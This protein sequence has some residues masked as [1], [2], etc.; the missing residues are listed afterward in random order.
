MAA[1]SRADYTRAETSDTTT[2]VPLLSEDAME[3]DTH[4][5]SNTDP[6]L[7][8][9]D[10]EK[11]RH[12][13]RFSVSSSGAGS[14]IRSPCKLTK[15]TILVAVI[16][17]LIII[18]IVLSALLMRR[19]GG[20]CISD[21][22]ICVTEGCINAAYHIF[23]SM[24]RSVDPCD[25]FYEYACGGWVQ[26]HPI[27]ESKSFWGVYS[28][29]SEQ[30]ERI[31]K[32]LLTNSVLFSKATKKAKTFYNACMDEATINKIGSKPL[33]DII[34]DLGGWNISSK[35][36]AWNVNN[37][38]FTHLL[39]TVHKKYSVSAF[40]YTNVDAD[41]KNSLKNIIKVKENICQTYELLC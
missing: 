34:K 31:V 15:T 38:S 10:G 2:N 19:S 22:G 20:K 12:E 3:D 40:F 26:N 33:L 24:N 30:N 16:A 28:V 32:Q 37:F 25:N 4:L 23:H 36:Q 13:V 35:S 14:P 41:D 18:C 7:V 17:V 8:L 39:E 6:V 27:P 5:I 11:D 29:L 9:T 21:K 1:H